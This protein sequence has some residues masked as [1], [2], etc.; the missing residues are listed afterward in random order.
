MTEEEV[1]GRI[2]IIDK[3]ADMLEQD[4]PQF[5]RFLFCKAATPPDLEV[6]L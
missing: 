2:R 3:F 6:L 1:D 4:N 5:N